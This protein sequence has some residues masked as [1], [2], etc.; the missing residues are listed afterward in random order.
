MYMYMYVA[1]GAGGPS[2]PGR[3]GAGRGV[4]DA[5]RTEGHSQEASGAAETGEIY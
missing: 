4:E 1:L 5:Q 2:T 3:Q